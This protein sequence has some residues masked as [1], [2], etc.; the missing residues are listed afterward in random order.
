MDG[1]MTP[2]GR[3]QTDDPVI[4]GLDTSGRWA[5][6]AL[7][8]GDEVLAELSW[9]TG[10]RHTAELFPNLERLLAIGGSARTELAGLVVATGPGTF[11]GL[12]TGVSAAKG[13]AFALNIQ[14]IGVSSFEVRALQMAAPG[15]VLCPA[16]SS[17]RRDLAAAVYRWSGDELVTLID[18]AVAPIEDWIDRVPARSVV[19]GELRPEVADRLIAARLHVL[20]ES[21]AA[22]RASQ[23]IRLARPRWLAGDFDD[24]RSLQPFYLRPPQITEAGRRAGA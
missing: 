5:G 4:L 19:I 14:V 21:L 3:S 24:P 1:T 13:L 10:L 2:L 15:V 17:G 9:R 18:P 11:N 6:L 7:A 22:P 12:R 23:A 16:F 8:R 20:P